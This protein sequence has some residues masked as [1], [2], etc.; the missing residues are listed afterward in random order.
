MAIDIGNA[1][2]ASDKAGNWWMLHAAGSMDAGSSLTESGIASPGVNPITM[3]GSTQYFASSTVGFPTSDFSA[4][5]SLKLTSLA[6]HT[7]LIGKWGVNCPCFYLEVSSAGVVTFGISDSAPAQLALASGANLSAGVD[8]FVGLSYKAS[9][10]AMSLRVHGVTTTATTVNGGVR[11][12]FAEVHSFGGQAAG[13]FGPIGGGTFV[14]TAMTASYGAFYTEKV[15]SNADIDRIGAMIVPAVAPVGWLQLNS[16][17]TSGIA[18]YANNA[19]S[20]RREIGERVS[21]SDGTLR[22]TMQAMK[23]D[24]SFR[25][26]PLTASDAFAWESFIRGEGHTYQFE[27]GGFGLYSSK[28]AVP[29]DTTGCTIVGSA[30]KFGSS[31]LRISSGQFITDTDVLANMYGSSTT[32]T[33]MFWISTDSGA[34]WHHYVLRSDGA[35]WVDGVRNDGASTSSFVIIASTVK[36]YSNADFDDLVIFSFAVLDAWPPL[37]FARTSA[38]PNTPYLEATGGMVNEQPV[39]LVAGAATATVFRTPAS[40]LNTELDVTLTAR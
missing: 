35:K 4:V 23:R 8:D 27:S 3:N 34:T 9:T 31:K 36:L 11:H 37:F 40:K 20:D 19:K 6:N 39:R 10:G 25:S 33:V 30:A 2:V 29:T 38:Y 12:D 26:V 21:A 24:V 14:T 22:L 7:F 5:I 28:G 13:S 17:E 15:L 1:V 32:Y 16:V 18:S